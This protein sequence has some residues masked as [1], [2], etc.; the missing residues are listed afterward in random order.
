MD[1]RK[2]TSQN[3]LAFQYDLMWRESLDPV[4]IANSEYQIL[5]G[6][7]AMKK[8]F[9]VNNGSLGNIKELFRDPVI[10]SQFSQTLIL[11][12]FVEDFEADL[13]TRDKEIQTCIIHMVQYTNEEGIDTYLGF[14]R[15]ITRRK[16]AEKKLLMAEKLTVTGKIAR[17]IAHELR[18]PMTNLNLTIDQLADELREDSDGELYIEIFKR[19]L[20]RI[21]NLISEL[22][23]SSKPKEYNFIE[24][25]IRKT[26]E[27]AID[28][29]VDRY[30][31]KKMKIRTELFSDP[32]LLPHDKEQLKVALLNLMVNASEA[33]EEG[34]GV[35]SVNTR[36]NDEEVRIS[37]S[38]N[39]KGIEKENISQLFE[40]F[41][42]NSK[43]KGMGLG[44]T[45][46][47][48]IIHGHRGH[49][50]VESVPGEGTTFHLFLPDN[51]EE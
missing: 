6:N 30:T 1:P 39:G 17:T 13:Y 10:F 12:N 5:E 16:R 49:I 41:F 26:I 28:L 15:N 35:L 2:S 11:N 14:V 33:M 18:N 23:N 29:V 4:F 47:Q 37:I 51:T 25:D 50:D 20:S 21:E 24:E 40:P 38:D 36:A 19:N 8:L 43:E 31:L 45:A 48:N 34:K 32:I 3:K 7:P 22:L 9:G 27:E 42:S 44:L 46:V